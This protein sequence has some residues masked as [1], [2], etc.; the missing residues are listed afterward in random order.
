ML[1]DREQLQAAFLNNHA[2]ND[3]KLLE[4]AWQEHEAR[5]EEAPGDA[6]FDLGAIIAAARAHAQALHDSKSTLQ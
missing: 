1:R 4:R 6:S 5:L 3:G 2:F